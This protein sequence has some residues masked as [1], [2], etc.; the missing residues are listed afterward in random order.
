VT[1][2]TP[3]EN[4]QA[5]RRAALAAMQAELEKAFADAEGMV[6]AMLDP[7]LSPDQR[8][9]IL[10]SLQ[11]WPRIVLGLYRAELAIAQKDRE[12]KGCPKFG[13]EEPSEIAQRVLGEA[14]DLGP[15]RIRDLCKTGR[16][17]EKEGMPQKAEI[18]AAKFK[19]EV[20]SF[21]V[22]ES[23]AA[24]IRELAALHRELFSV[25]KSDAFL[26]LEE[27]FSTGKPLL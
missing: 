15:D 13:R 6:Q 4:F 3:L 2:R 16:R 22:P 25:Q 24:A 23:S 27:K 19:R 17:H 9:D 7:D 1:K 11:A 26:N 8:L 5:F 12:E 21:V 18:T 20:L 10:K 14:L